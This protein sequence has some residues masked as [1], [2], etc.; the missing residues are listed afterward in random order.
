V[1]AQPAE[2]Y[3]L[4]LT[5]PETAR[6]ARI[7][8]PVV[9]DLVDAMHLTTVTDGNRRV[10]LT[11]SSVATL[12]DVVG[13]AKALREAGRTLVDL[14]DEDPTEDDLANVHWSYL[15]LCAQT[16]PEIFFPAKGESTAPAK[17]V[18]LACEVRTECLDDALA[19][20]D[21]MG[22]WGG[23]SERERRRVRHRTVLSA[24]SPTPVRGQLST[25]LSGQPADRTA[26]LSTELSPD[27]RTPVRGQVSG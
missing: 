5:I 2:V 7:P 13:K 11:P 9:R 14:P 17:R 12:L 3:T 19:N 16:D 6:A 4:P 26:R 8:R 22:V 24:D 21:R 1:S 27:S 15:A 20:S 18:C 25:E 23:L 10:R